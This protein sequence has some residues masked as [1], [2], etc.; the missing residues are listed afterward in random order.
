MKGGGGGICSACD[1]V[2]ICYR[3]M[4]VKGEVAETNVVV[5]GGAGG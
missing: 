3:K 4:L 1:G 2:Y 5:E